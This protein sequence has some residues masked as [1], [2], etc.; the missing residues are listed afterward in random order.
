MITAVQGS[1]KGWLLLVGLLWGLLT[2]C[3]PSAAEKARLT[4]L[5]QVKKIALICFVGRSK[6]N[7]KG[8]VHAPLALT[9][10]DA[11][12]AKVMLTS[13]EVVEFIPVKQVIDSDAYK[14]VA[15]VEMPEGAISGVEGLTYV[16]QGTDASD[17]F[18]CGPLVEALGVDAVMAVVTEFGV[19]V[20]E[21]K[22]I[23]DGPNAFYV[24]AKVHAFLAPLGID[25]PIWGNWKQPLTFKDQIPLSLISMVSHPI[26]V[27]SVGA[28]KTVMLSP[29]QAECDEIMQI[30]IDGKSKLGIMAGEGLMSTLV[31]DIR[32]ARQAQIQ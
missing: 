13:K 23:P 11:F 25:V 10:Y 17:Q 24:T 21:D 29:S 18:D 31:K 9:M 7:P 2:G 1:K 3:G 26:L 30:A 19:D 27:G 8:T 4:K 5:A 28:K 12:Q 6:T 14:Q 32:S 15:R 22:S 16:K 20:D